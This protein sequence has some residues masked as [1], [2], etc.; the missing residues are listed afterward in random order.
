MRCFRF[1]IA[2]LV[3]VPLPSASF[4]RGEEIPAPRLPRDKLLVYRGANNEQLPVKTTA[5][6]LK[7][8]AEI[9][10]GAQA[11]MGKLPGKEKRCPLDPK[12]EEEVDCGSYV[13]RF[14]TYASEPG[15]RVPCRHNTAGAFLPSPL[16]KLFGTHR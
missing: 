3:A 14:V 1:W 2:L 7:R 11:V 12:I 13:R 15:S 9:L 10:Q 5:D 16:S 4:C 8:R 6:W